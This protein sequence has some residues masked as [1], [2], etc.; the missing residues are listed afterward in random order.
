MSRARS[1]SRVA[2]VELHLPGARSLKDK[3]QDLRSLVERPAPPASRC[4]SSRA[5]TRSSTSARRWLCS[6]RHRRGGGARHRRARPRPRPRDLLG[7]R[8]GRARQRRAGP[9]GGEACVTGWSAA[10]GWPRRSARCSR[11]FCS[12]RSRTRACA[13]VV[14]SARRAL[15]D[16]KLARA[17]FSV[18]GDEERERQAADGLQ[19]ARGFLRR[20]SGAAHAHAQPAGPRVPPRPGLRARGPRPAHPG[21]GDGPEGEHRRGTRKAAAMSDVTRD[22]TAVVAR[23]RK[24]KRMLITSHTAPD[25][26]AIGSELGLRRAGTASSAP[27][28]R[29]STATRTRP[30]WRSSPESKAFPWSRRAARRLRAQLRPRGRPRVP[31]ARPPRVPGPGSASADPQHRPPPGQ[32]TLRRCSTIVDEEAPAVGE[33]VLAMADAAGAD[34]TRDHG[35]QPVHGPGHRHRRLPLLQRDAAGVRGR[36]ATG[37]GRRPAGTTSPSGSREHVPA[38]VV[39]LTA[40]VLATLELLAGGRL[41]V[42]S[43]DRAMLERPAPSRR[44]PRT[45]INIPRAIDGVRVAVL[46]QGVPATASVRVSLRSRERVDVQSVARIF[47]GGGHRN[48]AGCTDPGHPRRGPARPARRAPPGRGVRMS[49]F[50]SRLPAGGQA[51]RTDLP[52]RRAGGP[53][54]AARAPHRPHRHARPGRHRPARC[55]ASARRRG[56]SSTCS[57]GRRP[58]TARSASASRPRPTTPRA[59]RSGRRGRCPRSTRS[60]LADLAA[61]F[62]GEL[63]AAPAALLGQEDRPAASSTSWRAPARRCPREPKRVTVHEIELESVGADRLG[64]GVTCSSGTYVRSLAHDIGET[65]GCGG[66][67]ASLRR[68]RIGPWRVEHAVSAEVLA[69]RPHEIDR[70]GVR[71]ALRGRA[72]VP[73]GDAQ[74]DRPGPLRP[75]PGGRRARGRRA[76]FVPGSPGG[77]PRP[78]RRAR[79]RSA[80]RSPYLPRARTV[81]VAPRMVLARA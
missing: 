12:P 35:D 74:P 77:G 28:P 4:W 29:S 40:A 48:A 46:A 36:G 54:R 18:F 60:V 81:N 59:S 9:L 5:T 11:S 45:S 70:Q 13:G 69:N 21:R 37:R 34:V 43:C 26:D 19:Q 67:L 8:A 22:P 52:R 39:R 38:R 33:M 6:A 41:A 23:L 25:G 15:G 10:S 24:I 16:L 14:I 50:R 62:T 7:R 31:G 30:R 78:R 63:A 72:A 58:T 32:R 73:R 75:R 64:F 56:C 55:C 17:F 51:G 44:T 76:T 53:P 47:G 27:R 1:S 3:R 42:I 71:L 65:L 80:W 20:E 68:V 79:R 61:R 49:P 2:E 57:R 66:H